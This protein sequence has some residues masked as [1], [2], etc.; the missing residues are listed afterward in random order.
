MVDLLLD[1]IKPIQSAINPALK[2]SF[3][4]LNVYVLKN[5]NEFEESTNSRGNLEMSS[6]DIFSSFIDT[7][8]N[9]YTDINIK[10]RK[11]NQNKLSPT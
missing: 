5:W 9:T 10:K 1:Y 11:R 7:H 3:C 2:L 6:S 8:T 4:H